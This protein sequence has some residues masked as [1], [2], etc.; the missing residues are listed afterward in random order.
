VNARVLEQA[1]AK[2]R[3]DQQQ[4]GWSDLAAAL[5]AGRRV[6]EAERALAAERGEPYATV[7][8][9]GLRWGAGA[10]EPHLVCSHARAILICYVGDPDPAWDGTSVTVVSPAD[11]HES[12]FAVIEFDRHVTVRFGHPNDEVLSGHPLWGRG[13][14]P[15]AA[16]EV[17]NSP[18]LA[19]HVR[20]NSVHPYHDD[21]GWAP[22]RHYFLAFHDDVVDIL[23]RD[24]SARTTRGTMRSLLTAASNAVV[25]GR[26]LL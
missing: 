26:P 7:L 8:D 11:T 25:D 10:P 24:I 2:A 17:H 20:I 15:Y 14:Q 23:A 18:L 12:T 21:A 5:E 1:L 22:V 13:L 3:R 19:E 4:V 16:H 6:L 9:L